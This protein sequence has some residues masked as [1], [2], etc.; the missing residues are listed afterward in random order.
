MAL[1]LKVS[2]KEKS[3]ASLIRVYDTT[4]IYSAV[5][6]NLSGWQNASTAFL[7]DV[8]AATITV[9]LTDTITLL[10]STTS[11]TIDV[12]PT[13]PNIINTPYEVTAAMLGYTDGVIPDGIMTIEY[14]VTVTSG[15][16][17]TTYTASTNQLNYALACCCVKNLLSQ[18]D[19]CG[20]DCEDDAINAALY[21]WTELKGLQRAVECNKESKA[22]E[23]LMALQQYCRGENCLTCK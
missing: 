10:P 18:V 7:T 11:V 16:V 20:C 4:G 12:Y 23:I 19:A 15:V 9:Y 1:I 8:T 6:G 14:N 3:D 5:L 17:R 22:I 21:A 13:L 2:A